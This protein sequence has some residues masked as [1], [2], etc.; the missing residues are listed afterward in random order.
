MSYKIKIICRDKNQLYFN[1][2]I[3]KSKYL[4]INGFNG[5]YFDETTFPSKFIICAFDL[6]N[7][8]KL[9][10]IAGLNVDILG[11]YSIKKCADFNS[12]TIH[13]NYR[14]RGIGHLMIDY[15]KKY[16]KLL[17]I[18]T[19]VLSV[20]YINSKKNY[21]L[22]N[23]YKKNG[24]NVFIPEKNIITKPHYINPKNNYFYENN[25]TCM[26]CEI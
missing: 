4:Y 15:L 6:L 17:N 11:D 23:Y 25:E 26:K 5:Y 24:F 1:S 2:I 16:L 3:N 7:K 12:F 13:H 21:K 8:N 9:I 19:I 14:K 18:E 22:I 20:E 10:G